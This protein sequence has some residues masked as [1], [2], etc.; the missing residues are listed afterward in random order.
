VEFKANFHCVSIQ[1]RKDPNQK[2]YDLPYLAMNNA[3]TVVLESWPSEWRMASNLL[4]GSSKSVAKQKKEET[5]HKMQQLA[6]EGKK[7]AEDKAKVESAAQ[8]QA[9][10]EEEE[11]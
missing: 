8:K 4:V 9:E 6:T 2:W 1:A 5:R 3:I 11:E 10:E 7:E